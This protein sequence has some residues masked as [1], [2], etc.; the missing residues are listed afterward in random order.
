MVVVVVIFW[1]VSV[2]VVELFPV[3][4]GLLTIVL[5]S[6]EIEVEVERKVLVEVTAEANVE[7]EVDGRDR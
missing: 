7:V 2:I 1:I 3:S 4:L 6:L 5:D